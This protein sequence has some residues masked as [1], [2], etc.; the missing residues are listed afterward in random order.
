MS[1][2]NIDNKQKLNLSMR[3][4]FVTVYQTIDIDS[5]DNKKRELI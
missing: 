1:I 3:V 5:I 2:K 4:F